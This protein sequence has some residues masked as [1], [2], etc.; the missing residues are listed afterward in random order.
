MATY[1]KNPM[2]TTIEEKIEANIPK[3]NREAYKR[4][5]IAAGK[6]LFS[7]KTNK[8][9]LLV[10]DPESR[11][12]PVETISTGVIELAWLLYVQS[13]KQMP[14]EVLV[15]GCVVVACW[16]MD[17]AERSYGIEITPDLIAAVTKLTYEKMFEKLGV[18]PEQLRE[19][20]LQ[21][22]AEM[23]QRQ[24]HSQY[25]DSKFKEVKTK[26]PAAKKGGK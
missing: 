12:K 1:M 16:V 7:E 18:T 8:N 13:D 3:E 4:M 22:K 5:T 2:L 20:I 11:K 26:K 19:A 6:M 17:F 24:A 9:M 23:D 25:M 15:P 21:G 14:A 10:K